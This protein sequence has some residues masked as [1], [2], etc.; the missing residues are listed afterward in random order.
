MGSMQCN[1]WEP[2]VEANLAG[3]FG[4]HMASQCCLLNPQGSDSVM[5]ID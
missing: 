2:G 4:G 5:V 3:Q 1:T